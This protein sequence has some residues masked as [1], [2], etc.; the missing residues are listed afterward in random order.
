[1][2]DVIR[3]LVTGLFLAACSKDDPSSGSFQPARETT[4]SPNQGSARPLVPGASDLA[5]APPGVELEWDVPPGWSNLPVTAM[6]VVNLRVA[7]SEKSECYLVLL[8]GDSGGLQS[9][10]DRWRNQMGLPALPPAEVAGLPHAQLFGRDGVLVDFAGTWKGMNGTQNDAGWRLTGILQVDQGGSAFLKMTGP[11]AL[12]AAEKENF[13]ALARSI[14]PSHAG[15]HA[16]SETA[17]PAAPPMS[18][19]DPAVASMAGDQQGLAWMA[20]GTWTKGL[21]K[22][23]RVV[24]YQTPGGAECYVTVMGGEAG[25]VGSNINRWRDQ[26]GCPALPT[27]ELEKLEHL[28]MLGG[29]GRMVAIEGAGAQ[30][31]KGLLGALVLA[32]TRTVFVKMTG[33]KDA[34]AKENENFKAFAQ[35]LKEAK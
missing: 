25:G 5:S 22:A 7:G 26:M 18:P 33:P 19:T 28:A 8:G 16:G 27:E 15:M 23:Q 30:A 11:D 6:R 20:P 34:V 29:D 21:E 17:T 14:R 13:L 24:T 35:S 12:I 32:G 3:V 4:S 9:N 31:G 1:M 10:I 2:N